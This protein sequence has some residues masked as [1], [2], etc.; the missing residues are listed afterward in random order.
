M[1]SWRAN[2]DSQ[3]VLTIYIYKTKE[4]ASLARRSAPFHLLT[5]PAH[6]RRH[7]WPTH[8]QCR[9]KKEPQ[10]TRASFPSKVFFKR[11]GSIQTA[12]LVPATKSSGIDPSANPDNPLLRPSMLCLLQVSISKNNAVFLFVRPLLYINYNLFL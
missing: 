10:A 7:H 5:P 12:K 11:Q 3:T 2:T 9:K 8:T 1:A 4:R 6:R